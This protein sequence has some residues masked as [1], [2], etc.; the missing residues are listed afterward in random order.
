MVEEKEQGTWDGSDR[1][2]AVGWHLKREISVG[3]ILTTLSIAAAM[4]SYAIQNEKNHEQHR[5]RIEAIQE[6]LVELRASDLR[7]EGKIEAGIV[8]VEVQ[9]QRLDDKIERLIN[10]LGNGNGNGYGGEGGRR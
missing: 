9:M 8:R 4:I 2:G 6:R 5:L 10:R 3:H 1:R 7:Q